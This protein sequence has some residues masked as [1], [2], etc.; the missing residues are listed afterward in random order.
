MTGYRSDRS[1]ILT[2]VVTTCRASGAQSG[3]LR[4]G[5]WSDFCH[6]AWPLGLH[7]NSDYAAHSAQP[8]KNHEIG[9]PMQTSPLV[10]GCFWPSRRCRSLA[11]KSL[12]S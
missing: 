9:K 2:E 8:S 6:A 3:R 7:A 1:T 12:R 4:G 11:G 5:G 10:L